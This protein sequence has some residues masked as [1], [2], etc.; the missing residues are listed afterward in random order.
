M[1]SKS[2]LPVITLPTRIN[3]QTATLIDHIWTN[4]VNM[5]SKSGIILNALSDHFPVIYF[6]QGRHQKVQLPDNITRKIDSKTIPAFCKLLKST[7]WS[8]VLSEQDPKIAFSN[9][10]Q[11]IDSARDLAFPEIKVKSKPIK[12][13]HN[14]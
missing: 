6:E 11:K 13:K 14:P 3:Q 2:F 5:S 9:F 1:I 4:K 12:F 10:F 7:S 8:N